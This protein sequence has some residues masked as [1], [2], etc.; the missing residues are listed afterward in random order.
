M[1]YLGRL[2][3]KGYHFLGFSRDVASPQTCRPRPKNFWFD[4]S[5]TCN[6]L[7]VV[8][9]N[10]EA[11]IRPQS[12]GEVSVY[13]SCL[14]FSGYVEIKVSQAYNQSK[15]WRHPFSGTVYVK[16]Q[17]FQVYERVGK[18]V[19]SVS[20][21]IKRADICIIFTAMKQ[22]RKCS[23][24]GVYSYEKTVNLKGPKRDAKF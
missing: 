21:R 15:S 4:H 23:G 20:L 11:S 18:S 5:T 17:E 24:F 3:P 1:A 2:P 22:L 9:V 10:Q 8:G 7:C 13:Q 16:S 14:Q 19:I 12:V 6:K